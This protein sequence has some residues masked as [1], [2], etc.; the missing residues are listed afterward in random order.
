MYR[1]TNHADVGIESN[2]QSQ[3]ST[4]VPCKHV[5]SIDEATRKYSEDTF[6]AFAP[7]ES[8]QDLQGVGLAGIIVGSLV[9]AAMDAIWS[10]LAGGTNRACVMGLVNATDKPLYYGGLYIWSG[11]VTTGLALMVP[12]G[13]GEVP[14]FEHTA[15]TARGSVGV[16]GID[17]GNGG[18]RIAILWSVPYSGYSYMNARVYP[19]GTAV[20]YDM[21]YN[22]YY[23]YA[24][25]GAPASSACVAAGGQPLQVTASGL[26]VQATLTTDNDARMYIW[27]GLSG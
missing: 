8:R 4:H 27:I 25:A 10:N 5:V 15:A 24:D 1:T 23:G 13:H 6:A 17:Y 14:L 9:K 26:A 12:P 2:L 21:A 11:Q 20:N 7:A 19:A 3:G 18:S 22:M 16:V